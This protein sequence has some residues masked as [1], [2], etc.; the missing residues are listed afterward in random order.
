MEPQLLVDFHTHPFDNT[1]TI[2]G[3]GMRTVA[4]TYAP[5]QTDINTHDLG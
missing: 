5:S 1:G 3:M 4:N 2:D